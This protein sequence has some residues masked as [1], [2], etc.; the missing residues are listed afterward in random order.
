MVSEIMTEYHLAQL[1]I[2]RARAPLDDPLL[3][4]FMA[5]LDRINGLA[6]ASPGFVWR[7]QSDGGNAT[8]I[9]AYDDPHML[10]NL[11]LWESPEAL[12]DFV[13]KTG[14]AKIMTRRGEWFERMSTPSTVLWWVPAGHR[15]SLAEATERLEHLTK[16][17]ATPWAFTFKQRFPAPDAVQAEAG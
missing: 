2:A 8:D 16:D 15:P 3:A 5:A 11:S 4:D 14:H 17:G 7:L 6:E 12:F 10:I 13:Y 1:N 9:R